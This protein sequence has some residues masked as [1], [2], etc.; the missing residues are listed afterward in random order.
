MN[1]DM[2]INKDFI[3]DLFKISLDALFGTMVALFLFG[4]PSI[5]LHSVLS[6]S[7]IWGIV[8]ALMPD[9]LHFVY[10]KLWRRE[11]LLSL[12]RLHLLINKR[13]IHKQIERR[14]ALGISLQIIIIIAIVAI[15][16]FLV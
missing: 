11:P 8:G 9:F 7:I 13:E 2:L 5:N 12:E 4:F 16:K 10:F 3:F 15:F 14:Y 6:S 1:E